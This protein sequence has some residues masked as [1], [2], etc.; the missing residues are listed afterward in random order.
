MRLRV[1]GLPVPLR[2][3]PSLRAYKRIEDDQYRFSVEASLPLLG[4]AL[5]YHGLLDLEP[6]PD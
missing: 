4:K 3:F 2:L 1:F 6:L 5:R